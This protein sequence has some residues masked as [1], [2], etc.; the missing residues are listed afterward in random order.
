MAMDISLLQS[1]YRMTHV[2]LYSTNLSIVG[3]E[4][5]FVCPKPNS[6]AKMS[7]QYPCFQVYIRRYA[8]KHPGNKL[9]GG[10]QDV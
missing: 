2:H 10:I 4:H 8:F 6:C 5:V 9:H 7:L 1:E 3:I